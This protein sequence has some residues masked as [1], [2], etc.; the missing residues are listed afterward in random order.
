MSEAILIQANDWEG[1]FVNGKLIKEGYTINEGISRIK[2]FDELSQ[3]YNFS[4]NDL[5]E[6]WIDEKDEYY[7][8]LNGNF[9]ININ[10]MYGKY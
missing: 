6:V 8:N 2:V 5:K 10:D 1:L 7:L 4:L 9:P 3:Q